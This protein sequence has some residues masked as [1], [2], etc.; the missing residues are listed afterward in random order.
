M[1]QN[2]FTES[3]NSPPRRRE[4][5][6]LAAKESSQLRA[7]ES[8]RDVTRSVDR[9]YNTTVFNVAPRVNG[10]RVPKRI[11]NPTAVAGQRAQDAKTGCRELSR[12]RRSTI[13]AA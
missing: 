11:S 13:Q 8:W 12:L 2:A 4:Q 7:F 10:T 9:I 1:T 6:A 5:L 3:G